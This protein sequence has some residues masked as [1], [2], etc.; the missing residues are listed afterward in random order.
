MLTQLLAANLNVPVY[1]F[2]GWK[3]AFVKFQLGDYGCL[4]PVCVMKLWQRMLQ[5]MFGLE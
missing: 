3:H 5:E 4:I 1:I 2:Y